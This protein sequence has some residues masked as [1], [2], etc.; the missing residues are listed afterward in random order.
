MLKAVTLA[1]D[2]FEEEPRGRSL[3]D[4]YL[5]ASLLFQALVGR[6]LD[7]PTMSLALQMSRLGLTPTPRGTDIGRLLNVPGSQIMCSAT[8]ANDLGVEPRGA[9]LQAQS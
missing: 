5:E 2:P 7:G 9:W 6:Q 4:I 1:L 3:P 8:L